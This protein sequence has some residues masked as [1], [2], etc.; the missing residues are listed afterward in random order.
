MPVYAASRI[1]RQEGAQGMSDENNRKGPTLNGNYMAILAVCFLALLIS[2]IAGTDRYMQR[3]IILI[4]LWAAMSSGFN[5]ISG[6]AGQVV[7]GYMM[8]VGTG[9]YTA[10]LLFKFLGVSPWLGMWIGALAAVIAAFI[11]GLPT[12]R[13]RSHYFA[14]ATIA[15]PLIMSP[16]LNHLGFE[17]V[18]IPFS[19]QGPSSMQFRDLVIMC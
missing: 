19:G 7:F 15:F 5:L 8:F 4:A 18:S 11:I 3:M 14:V 1:V 6:Y 13:L 2:W 9:A 17:E 16:I 10:V 12:L